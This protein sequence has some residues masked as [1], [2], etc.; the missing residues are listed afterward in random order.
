MHLISLAF[1]TIDNVIGKDSIVRF[2]LQ[3]FLHI[4]SGPPPRN[5]AAQGTCYCTISFLTLR[6]INLQHCYI[7]G[8]L[9]MQICRVRTWALEL[10]SWSPRACP[11]H[12]WCYLRRAI[13]KY[14]YCQICFKLFKKTNNYNYNY[15]LDGLY[16]NIILKEL[17]I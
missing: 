14:I 12:R 16:Y 6:R 9:Y 15:Y 10:L 13:N 1:S 2:P 3:Y 8:L 17:C 5:V 4:A 11:G 7:L